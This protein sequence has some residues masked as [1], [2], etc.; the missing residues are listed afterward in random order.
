MKRKSPASSRSGFFV[1]VG[2]PE[3]MAY[4]RNDNKSAFLPL[5]DSAFSMAGLL[6]RGLTCS[7]PTAGDKSR[8][9][10]PAGAKVGHRQGATR[11]QAEL[12]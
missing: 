3:E 10:G 2:V 4:F 1:S 12:R 9:A 8:A 11:Q 5:R 6:R 7:P